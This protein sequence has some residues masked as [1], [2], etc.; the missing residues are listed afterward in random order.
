[1]LAAS[2]KECCGVF[3]TG[4]APQKVPGLVI[5]W[6]PAASCKGLTAAAQDLA[7]WQ[8]GCG[9]HL[10]PVVPDLITGQGLAASSCRVKFEATGRV[11]AKVRLCVCP[12]SAPLFGRSGSNRSVPMQNLLLL[13]EPKTLGVCQC[14]IH[15]F[16]RNRKHSVC[17]NAEFITFRKSEG[18]R[19]VSMRK[20]LLL[21]ELQV[22]RVCPCTIYFF[23]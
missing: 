2:Q 4:A 23:S 1:M 9:L 17:A 11:A 6:R 10:L 16:L 3:R 20:V 19:C 8:V 18:I 12:P 5:G 15:Y 7:M 21:A 14:R 13:A 22:L